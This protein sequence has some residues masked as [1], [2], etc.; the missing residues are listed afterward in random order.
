MLYHDH[1]TIVYK[2][3]PPD[4]S[5]KKIM[6]YISVQQFKQKQSFTIIAIFDTTKNH[7]LKRHLK[8]N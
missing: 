1:N 6:L 4:L 5:N 8:I 7:D 3:F 2:H